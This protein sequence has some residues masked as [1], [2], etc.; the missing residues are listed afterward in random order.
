MHKVTRQVV[1]IS[2]NSCFHINTNPSTA[3]K[4]CDVFAINTN[5]STAI[6][7]CDVF[8]RTF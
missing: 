3:I 5:P 7:Q 1:D 6:K 2:L 8:L 4:P